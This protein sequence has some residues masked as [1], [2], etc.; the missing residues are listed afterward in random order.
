VLLPRP[1]AQTLLLPVC[2]EHIGEKTYYL[3]GIANALAIPFVWA[4]YPETANRTLESIDIL[5]SGSIFAHTAE[6]N[7]KRIM[8]EREMN[9][10]ALD[11]ATV[12]GS[13]E[14][15]VGAGKKEA[16]EVRMNER[17]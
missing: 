16:A 17:V 7:Y 5:F 14:M 4:L 11:E 13:E 9:G 2:F 12:R 15:G 1:F 6:K 3:F 8:A 10:L